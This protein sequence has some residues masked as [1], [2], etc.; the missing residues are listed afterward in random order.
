MTTTSTDT[1]ARECS[2]EADCNHVGEA[3]G[4]EGSCT[5]DCDL[6][7][8]GSACGNITVVETEV[9][10]EGI[11][12]AQFEDN[13]VE[14][15]QQYAISIGKPAYMIKVDHVAEGRRMLSTGVVVVFKVLCATE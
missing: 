12:L 13:I 4:V 14:I 15:K 6:G 1:P 3:S 8:T 5:C 11:T 9:S 7:Y 10:F 2:R